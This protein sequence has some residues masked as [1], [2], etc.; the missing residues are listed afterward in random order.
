VDARAVVLAL[1]RR[2]TPRRL[3]VPGEDLQKVAYSLLDA[4]GYQG[5]RILVVGGGD[6]AVEAALGLAEQPGNEV[7]I[8]YRKEAFFRLKS[9]NEA[10]VAQ[11]IAAG[12]LHP[13]F[14]SRVVEIRPDLVVLE[15]ADGT[16]RGLAND[17]VFVFACGTPPTEVLAASG[18]SFDPEE[19]EAAPVLAEQGTGLIPALA[20]ALTL[21]LA[22]GAWSFAHADYYGAPLVERPHHPDH[23]LL[24]PTGS[25]G[26]AAGIAAAACV[27]ANLSYLARRSQRCAWIPGSLRAWMTAHV[28]TGVAALLLATAHSAMAPRETVGGHAAWALAFLVLTGAIGRYLYRFVLRAANG[29]E[30]E[31][32][33]V[34]S[35][36]AA[37]STEWDQGRGGFADALRTEVDR[38]TNEERWRGSLPRRLLQLW[39][40]RRS[41]RRRMRELRAIARSEGVT[42]DEIERLIDLAQRAQ[43][44]ALMTAHYEDLRGILASWRWFHRWVALFFV[45]V[46]AW[47][48]VV[49]LRFRPVLS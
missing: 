18:V 17:D 34:R 13:L 33:E 22:V 23:P 41:S 31:L 25:A 3:G 29:R 47:H 46:L 21:A 40:H 48:V 20:A 30:L 2:G 14:G 6:S 35:R 19:R 26:L 15:R 45:L 37:L 32:E 42:K 9:R 43:S 39:R 44:T 27:L 28:V 12:E 36:F 8:S 49:A 38:T 1:G 11:A 24:A 5:R 7:V 10:R 16:Q 4:H